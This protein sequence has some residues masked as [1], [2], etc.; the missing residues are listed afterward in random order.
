MA[1]PYLNEI[2]TGGEIK[3]RLRQ[4]T[5]EIAEEFGVRGA[6]DPRPVPHVT[7]YGP[8]D[9]NEGHEAKRI[10]KD[11]LSG[12]DIVPYRIDG[13]GRF[14]E[15]DVIYANVIP[16]PELRNLRRELARRLRPISRNN[17][18]HDSDYFHD[19]HITVAFRD[20]ADHFDEIWTYVQEE[21]DVHFDAYATRITSLH[22]REMMWEYDL[23]CD[24]ELSPNDATSAA[25]WERTTEVLNERKSKRDHASLSPLPNPLSRFAKSTAAKAMGRWP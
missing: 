16:S 2:R 15:N 4:I 18:R 6:V 9:T 14:E 1:A 23:P 25:S 12:Y 19:F 10:V 21:F 7:L 8:Y 11:V 22:R 3:H 5:H 13:F 24:R 20:I 17:P